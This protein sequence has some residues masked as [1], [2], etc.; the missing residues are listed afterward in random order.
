[1]SKNKHNANLKCHK[2][3]ELRLRVPYNMFIDM[4]LMLQLRP[5]QQVALDAL[6]ENNKGVCVFPTGGGK[7]NVGIF[8]A[9][10]QFKSDAPSLLLLYCTSIVEKLITLALPNLLRFTTGVVVLTNTNLSSPPTILYSNFNVPTLRLTPSTLMRH[11]ILFN[12]TSF[13]P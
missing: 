5:H 8:D 9:M 7:T 11:T 4:R 3:L 6:A 2:A 10:E 12:A 1:M 13:L